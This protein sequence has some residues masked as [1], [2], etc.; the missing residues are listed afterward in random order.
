MVLGYM[1]AAAVAEIDLDRVSGKLLMVVMLT[2]RHLLAGSF[3]D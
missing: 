1:T 2:V 3:I